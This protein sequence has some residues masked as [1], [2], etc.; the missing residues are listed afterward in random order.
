MTYRSEC[1]KCNGSGEYGISP[2]TARY[3]GPG[4]VPEDSRMAARVNCDCWPDPPPRKI[5]TDYIHPPIPTRNCDWAAYYD[6]D[7]EY[8]PRGWGTTEAEAIQDLKDN[9]GE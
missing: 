7:D 3:L 1:T 5:V 9:F 8:G 4:P 6:G 2:A